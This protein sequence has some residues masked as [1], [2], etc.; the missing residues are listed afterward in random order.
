MKHSVIETYEGKIPK[1]EAKM[2]KRSASIILVFLEN[3]KVVLQNNEIVKWKDWKVVGREVHVESAS[4]L[5]SIAPSRSGKGA[6]YRT[7]WSL[8][9]VI[10]W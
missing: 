2:L 5:N 7:N 1:E 10:Q 9:T 3:G 6:E 8:Q 4:V